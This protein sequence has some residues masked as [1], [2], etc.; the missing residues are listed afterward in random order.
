MTNEQ[1]LN[2]RILSNR[3]LNDRIS[4]KNIL[5]DKISDNRILNDKIS[6][7]QIFNNRMLNAV[8]LA[9]GKASNFI[10][11]NQSD[12]GYWLD[13]YIPGMG[14]SSQWVTAYIAYSLSRLPNTDKSVQKA[15]VWLLHTKFSSGGWG[16][17]Q[18]CLP[19]ADSTANVVR[20]LAYYFKKENLLTQENF[21]FYLH[22]FADLLASYQDR[23]TGGFLTYLPGSNG[24]YHTMPDSAWCISEP[25]ITAMAGNAF[26]T[27]GPEWFEQEISK[28]REFLISRQNSAG[29]WDSYWWDCRIYGTSLA[30]N[31]LKQLGEI[32]PVKKAISWLKSIFVPSK[33]WGNGYEAVPYP[34]YTALSLSSL[35]LFENNIHSRE[36]KD[37]VLWLIE[38]QNEDGSWF[39]KPI[40]RVPDPQVREPWVG[41]NR[42][43]CEVVTDVNLLFTTATVMG[44]LY[45]FLNL[46]G[47]YSG[48]ASHE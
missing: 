36:V 13:F 4:D 44:A 5:N 28:A 39:S 6:D 34:F 23:N 19:D 2:S 27:A 47:Y 9:I 30:C 32:D 37:S 11:S 29:Y 20:L 21:V 48:S 33:G 38:N 40:L 26:L 17:H 22:E 8:E 15:I 43:K 14:K 31:F 18:N 25:S 7:N 1:V 24:K 3:I 45:D 12:E 10:I 16:Y 42:E 46:S 41:S 35:L